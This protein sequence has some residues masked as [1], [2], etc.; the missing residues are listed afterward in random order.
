M[1]PHVAWAELLE[2][3]FVRDWDRA[4]EL[5]Q[6]LLE[7][8]DKGGVPPTT[9]GDS[10]LGKKWHRNIAHTACLFVL[11]DVKQARKRAKR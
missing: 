1:D 7:W 3:R 11:V 2:A 5:A 6:G 8:L 10:R 4:E 9:I